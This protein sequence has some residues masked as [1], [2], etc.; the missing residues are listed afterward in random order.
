MNWRI[1]NLGLH[2]RW[3]LCSL[4]S[5]VVKHI[6]HVTIL[7]TIYDL[8]SNVTIDMTRIPHKSLYFHLLSGNVRNYKNRFFL[9]FDFTRF[10]IVIFLWQFLQYIHVFSRT[11]RGFWANIVLL[12]CG[13]DKL[14]ITSTLEIP[15]SQTKVPCLCYYMVSLFMHVVATHKYGFNLDMKTIVRKLSIV[16]C[17]RLLA[18]F[19]NL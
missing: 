16:L 2:D 3:F 15:S 14:L 13:I 10:N 17:W 6:L 4:H 12:F 5:F 11:I 9:S 1:S 19:N 7:M 18:I 8:V